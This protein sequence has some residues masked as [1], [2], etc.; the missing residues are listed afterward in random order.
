VFAL[1]AWR[2]LSKPTSCSLENLCIQYGVVT[3]LGFVSFVLWD[4]MV[5][6]SFWCSCLDTFVERVSL[7]LFDLL[8]SYCR[9]SVLVTDHL[10]LLTTNVWGVLTDFQEGQVKRRCVVVD[11]V[12]QFVC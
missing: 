7:T 3:Q 6:G 5:G 11:Y 9:L 4:E 1:R 8:C 10:S 12:A 2:G